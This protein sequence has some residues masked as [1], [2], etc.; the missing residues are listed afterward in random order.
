MA[1][2]FG[3]PTGI[4]IV[5]TIVVANLLA[6]SFTIPIANLIASLLVASAMI[7][8][9]VLQRNGIG[10]IRSLLKQ[11]YFLYATVFGPTL[12]FF[13]FLWGLVDQWLGVSPGHQSLIGLASFFVIMLLVQ[14]LLPR[15]F[16][17]PEERAELNVKGKAVRAVEKFWASSTPLSA[18]PSVS[19]LRG[20]FGGGL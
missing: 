1:R 5:A 3:L 20:R 6:F 2:H 17:N 16:F 4:S 8:V 19:K 15:V 11:Q 10:P 7:G 13:L 9:L 14:F 12:L 18:V